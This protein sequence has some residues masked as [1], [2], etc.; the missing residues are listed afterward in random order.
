MD[1]EAVMQIDH[2]TL[3]AVAALAL[4]A[5]TALRLAFAIFGHSSPRFPW[6]PVSNTVAFCGVSL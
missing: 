2:F 3:R 6:A 5:T 1:A 4:Y